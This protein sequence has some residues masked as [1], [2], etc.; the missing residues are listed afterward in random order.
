[1]AFLAPVGVFEARGN[2]TR[3]VCSR[4]RSKVVVAHARPRKRRAKKQAPNPA[5]NPVAKPEPAG[6]KKAE[7]AVEAAAADV[8]PLDVSSLVAEERKVEEPAVK[9]PPPAGKAGKKK[10]RRKR[11]VVTAASRKE[12]AKDDEDDSAIA[13]LTKAFRLSKE[14]SLREIEKD[15]DYLFREEVMASGEK[16]DLLSAMMGR[17]RPNKQGTY[18]LPYLQSGHLILLGVVTVAIL[19]YN[20]GFP[21]TDLEQADRDIL[22]LGLKINFSINIVLSLWAWQAAKLRNQP[23]LFW[24]IKTIVLGGLALD[25]LR[26]NV[27]LPGKTRRR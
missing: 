5:A 2:G 12:A 26:S 19:V 6:D 17:G 16:Y 23:K 9:T 13:N 14:E 11:E 18:V 20:P 27:E 8:T 7:G 10:R 3:V 1:M 25:E 4:Q 24:V 21:L 15:P 22:S